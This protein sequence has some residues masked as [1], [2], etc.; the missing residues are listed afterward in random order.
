MI[1]E[2]HNIKD[3]LEDLVQAV[4]AIQRAYAQALIVDHKALA[5][6]QKNNDATMAQELLQRAFRTDVG[7][8]VP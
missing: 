1:D 7:P 5:E 4:E 2:S 6:A 8:L 3:P